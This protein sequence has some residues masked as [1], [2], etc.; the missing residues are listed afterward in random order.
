MGCGL[1]A[2]IGISQVMDARNKA[3]GDP[4]DKQGVFVA[5]LDIQANEELT[6]QNIKLE[7]WPKNIVPQGRA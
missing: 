7:E 5:M 4:G 2:S 3:G 6:A 1:V